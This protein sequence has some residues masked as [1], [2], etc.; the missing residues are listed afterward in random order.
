MTGKM[1]KMPT[2]EYKCSKCKKSYYEVRSISEDQK[3]KKCE[4]CDVGLIRVFGTPT[5]TFKGEGFYSVDKKS[6][7]QNDRTKV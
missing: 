6:R 2:Y 5:V 3:L 7:R 4:N 1:K